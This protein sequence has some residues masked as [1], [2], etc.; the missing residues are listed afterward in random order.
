[1]TDLVSGRSTQVVHGD[2]FALAIPD[3]DPGGR[4]PLHLVAYDA[5]G[6]VVA[7]ERSQP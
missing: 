2:L 4:T 1:V 6:T 3:A 7:D 5:A